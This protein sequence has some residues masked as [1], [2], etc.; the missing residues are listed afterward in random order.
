MTAVAAA[1]RTAGKDVLGHPR[2]LWYLVFCEGFERFSYYGMQALLVLYLTQ[3][4]L[5]PG[6]VEHVAAFVPFRG[7]LQMLFGQL[8][9]PVATATA[10]TG[11]YSGGVYLT[12]I[13]GGWIADQWLGRT[14]TVAAG[15]L[16]MVLGHFLMAF[17][18]AFV[19]AILCLFLGVG[20]FKGNIASQVGE[21]YKPDDLRRSNGYQV[22]LLGVQVAV[23]VAPLIIGTLGQKVAWH[24]GFGAAG[25]GMAVALVIYLA[26]RKNLPPER[27]RGAAAKA[28]QQKFTGRDWATIAVLVALL[29]VLAATAIGNQ[30]IFN[31]YLLWGNDHYNLAV[32][33][34]PSWIPGAAA[35]SGQTMPVTWLVSLDAFISAFTVGGALAFWTI[36]SR[37]AKEPDE[38]IKIAIGALIAA[39]AP[40]L[41]AAASAQEVATGQKASLIWGLGFHIINDVGFAM[42][43]PVG[44]ALYSRAAP[45]QVSG[46]FIGVYYLHLFI[47]NF[48][49]GRVAGLIEHMDGASFWTMHAAIIGVGAVVLL[50]FAFV[51]RKLLAPTA[52][53]K[54]ETESYAEAVTTQA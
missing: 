49:T 25:V 6:H 39:A 7:F 36:W 16:I 50:V 5:L 30:E 23:I 44:L 51:F 27:P 40:L 38:I 41:L 8:A 3:Y 2:G 24:W 31:A 33:N 17:D 11:L 42:I 1:Q 14:K 15:A 12:P 4:L 21:L 20:L 46:V 48:A 35:I 47:C 9:T 54:G 52:A 29:P 45:K 22:F 28:A 18:V 19:A 53:D 26:G 43:F 37:Y 13:L 10:I 32:P 34:L